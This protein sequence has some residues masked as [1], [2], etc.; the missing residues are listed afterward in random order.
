LWVGCKLKLELRALAPCDFAL[1]VCSAFLSLVAVSS[2]SDDGLLLYYP[3][4]EKEGTVLHDAG[5]HKKHGSLNTVTNG[6][7]RGVEVVCTKAGE[8][9]PIVNKDGIQRKG[10]LPGS[11]SALAEGE[12]PI[13][14][15]RDRD[16]AI[17]CA[18]GR[19]KAL[20]G[21]RIELRKPFTL[22]FKFSNT[23]PAWTEGKKGGGVKLDG[24][25]DYVALAS[26]PT[27]Q[28]AAITVQLW[29]KLSKDCSTNTWIVQS[30]SGANSLQLRLWDHILLSSHPVFADHPLYGKEPLTRERWQLVTTTCD[31]KSA[32]LYLDSN[33]IGG[34]LPVDKIHAEGVLRI[35]GVRD[36]EFLAA[37]VDEI[38]IY[39]RAKTAEEIAK[40][41]AQ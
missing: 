6:E 17:D 37:T 2:A 32:K 18:G 16:Y 31:G 13:V 7:E 10:I 12:R 30:V 21:G 28:L 36:P 11:D 5:P 41:A 22:D 39:N 27:H 14:L 3:C 23:G 26:L 33:E 4:D 19:I 35:G 20:E 8:W 34:G 29:I 38:K 25:D 24:V 40:D 15:D 9:V 1:A